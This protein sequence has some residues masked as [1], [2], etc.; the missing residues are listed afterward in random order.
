MKIHFLSTINNFT[1]LIY[2]DIYSYRFNLLNATGDVYT[3][4]QIYASASGAE[5]AARIMLDAITK[6]QW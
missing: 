5:L 6:T 1:L 3:S 4:K 2:K